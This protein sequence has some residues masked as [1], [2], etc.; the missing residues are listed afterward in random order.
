[1]NTEH[2]KG[3]TIQFKWI[4]CR[5]QETNG[6]KRIQVIREF[7]SKY[8]ALRYFR[9]TGLPRPAYSIMVEAIIL[10]PDGSKGRSF[11][12]AKK[13]EVLNKIKNSTF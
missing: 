7:D 6:A 4:V 10:E 12:A 13:E 1:M 8:D 3:K 5:K 9:E 2:Y 11:W